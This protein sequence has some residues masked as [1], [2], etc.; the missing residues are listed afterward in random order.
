MLRPQVA[1]GIAALSRRHGKTAG[2]F[3][4]QMTAQQRVAMGTGGHAGQT[5]FLD[6]A[7]LGGAKEPFHATLGLGAVG[8]DP[9][10]AQFRQGPAKLRLP[11]VIPPAFF[12]FSSRRRH[13]RCLSDWSSDVCSSD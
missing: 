3:W 2:E 7:I 5:Q 13:T 4:E 10:D 12:F 9:L 6:P 8:R 1:V 11:T